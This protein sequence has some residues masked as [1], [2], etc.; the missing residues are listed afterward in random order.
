MIIKTRG[1]VF[2]FTRY[3]ETSIITNIY[4]EE[5]GLGSYIVNGVRSA[6]GKGK[7][8]Y[9]EPLTLLD[10][11]AYH[12]PDRD[13]NRLN[14][15]KLAQPLHHIRQDVYKSSIIMF[16]AEILNKCILERDKNEPLFNFLYNSIQALDLIEHSANFHLQ[17]L[18]QLSSYL[19]FGIQDS[20]DFISQ[21]NNQIFY[22]TPENKQVF[23]SLIEQSYNSGIGLSK[24]QRTAI[25]N[26]LIFYY[27]QHIGLSKLKSLEVLNT[28]FS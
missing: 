26:D 10:L 18:I 24:D 13:I 5:A 17:F 14:E 7:M 16:L 19:G 23:E 1:I 11:T 25:L 28:I 2:R 27:Q 3:R 20:R 22:R 12:N 6:K 9:F 21:S 4:T 15:L 8:G